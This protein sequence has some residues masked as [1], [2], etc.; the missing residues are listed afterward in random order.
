MENVGKRSQYALSA[1]GIF[2]TYQYYSILKNLSCK[3]FTC[4]WNRHKSYSDLVYH[5]V[6]GTSR[7]S[8]WP[9]SHHFGTR[10]A[11]LKWTNQPTPSTTEKL[12]QNTPPIS[13]D[14]K[15]LCFDGP[16]KCS[17]LIQIRIVSPGAFLSSPSD[18]ATPDWD[19]GRCSW[20]PPH[21]IKCSKVLVISW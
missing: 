19:W 5:W 6:L 8:Y 7:R 14:T 15:T 11:R 1:S 9:Y 3:K 10:S 17:G 4:L 12:R 2:G 16:K 20:S 13:S 18:K 21:E